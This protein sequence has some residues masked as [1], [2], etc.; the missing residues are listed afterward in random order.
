MV[1]LTNPINAQN[2]VDRFADYVTTTV[3]TSI[4]YGTNALPFSEAP[5]SWFGGTTSG[6]GIG[7]TGASV[8]PGGGIVTA[9]NIYN[10]LVAETATYTNIRN[11][12][13]Q[14]FVQGGGGNTG[15]RPSPG[16]VVNVTNKTHLATSY[17][18]TLSTVA[19][20]GVITAGTIT[21]TG[22]EGFFQNLQDEW[23][24]KRDTGVT[25]VHTVCH[26]SCHSSCHGSRGRR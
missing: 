24:A 19:D 5:T 4:T 20:N 12:T 10:T 25:L 22:L 6:V 2:V 13:L 3:N 21:A 7:V 8:T 23:A 14:L 16:T 18:Q 15:S 1:S 17:R 9:Q 11:A 26:S